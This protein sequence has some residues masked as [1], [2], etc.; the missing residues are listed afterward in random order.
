M[1]VFGFSKDQQIKAQRQKCAD[2]KARLEKGWALCDASPDDK[3]LEEHWLKLH[4]EYKQAVWDLNVA[5]GK[6]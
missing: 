2:L 1:N 4:E 3:R 5:G 6:E